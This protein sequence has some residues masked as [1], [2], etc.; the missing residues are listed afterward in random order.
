MTVMRRRTLRLGSCTREARLTCYSN[1]H[2]EAT[3]RVRPQHA[4]AQWKRRT[5]EV[6]ATGTMR[7]D[8]QMLIELQHPPANRQT[9]NEV[10]PFK[11]KPLL[12]RQ[13]QALQRP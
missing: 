5:R 3:C 2:P 10:L 6:E 9:R 1:D 8:S 4:L 12:S 7:A 13:R 11:C